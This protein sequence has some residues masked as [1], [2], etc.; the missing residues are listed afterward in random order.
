MSLCQSHKVVN[1]QAGVIFIKT[2]GSPFKLNGLPCGIF[3]NISDQ[4]DRMVSDMVNVLEY[5]KRKQ[6]G[7]GI[8]E[9]NW[10]KG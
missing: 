8:V 6:K 4:L 7:Q 1:L 5:L 9:L 10:Y 2:Q 3:K